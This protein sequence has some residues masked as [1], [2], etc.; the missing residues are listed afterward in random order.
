MK[1]VWAEHAAYEAYIGRWSRRVAAA[2]VPR[3]GVPPG[4]RWLDVGCGTG[5]LV[6]AVLAVAEP[7]ATVGIDPSLGFLAGATGNAGAA[8]CA[9]DARALPFRDATFDAVVSG[10]ALNFV[11][12][13]VR[14]AAE[15]V[16][17]ARP[18]AV[19]AAYVWDYAGGMQMLRY[20]W[21]TASEVDDRAARLEEGRRF[22]LCRPEPL[23]DL[24]HGAGL[25]TATVAA[26]DVPTVFTDFADYWRPFL[27]GQGPA[28]GFVAAL[29]EH[30]RVA[31]REL[32]RSRLPTQDD[33]SIRL[34]ARAWA[35]Q[36]VK[37][38]SRTPGG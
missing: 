15:L 20:F 5:S 26:I 7:C 27:G 33:G 13:P 30:R 34:T 21:A 4:R 23:A 16:R 22:A 32:L 17:V 8:L 1:D 6:A 2:F 36:G 14:A 12:D 35:V 28:P 31:L 10:L 19:V 25:P 11:P 38:G 18:G 3:L 29:P 9:A 24:W 37:G